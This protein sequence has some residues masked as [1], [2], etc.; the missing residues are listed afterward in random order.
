M[1][2]DRW[3]KANSVMNHHVAASVTASIGASFIS[4]FILYLH[5]PAELTPLALMLDYNFSLKYKVLDP[6]VIIIFYGIYST[7]I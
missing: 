5:F 1:D 3:V 2:G 7:L 4:I 6:D